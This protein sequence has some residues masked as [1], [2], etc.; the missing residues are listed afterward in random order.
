MNNPPATQAELVKLLGFRA[1]E[2]YE[3]YQSLEEV[4]KDT[5]CFIEDWLHTPWETL[6]EYYHCPRGREGIVREMVDLAYDQ[7]TNHKYDIIGRKPWSQDAFIGASDAMV[8]FLLAKLGRPWEELYRTFNPEPRLVG[9]TPPLNGG[10]RQSMEAAASICSNSTSRESLPNSCE[11]CVT[12]AEIEGKMI[13][14]GRV[15]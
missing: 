15:R 11:R 6:A 14:A 3:R 12:D 13:E 1:H 8:G 5:L 4:C 9:N 7:N 10:I 2:H